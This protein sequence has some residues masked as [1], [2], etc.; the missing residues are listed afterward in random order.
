MISLII[1]L[2]VVGAFGVFLGH[3]VGFGIRTRR[4]RLHEPPQTI[5]EERDRVLVGLFERHPPKI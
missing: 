1:E 4:A 3:V 2:T 5:R